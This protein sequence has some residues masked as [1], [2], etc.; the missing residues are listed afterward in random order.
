MLQ[1]QPWQ[2]CR[3]LAAQLLI[4]GITGNWVFVPE[5][6]S[7]LPPLTQSGLCNL[8]PALN[9]IILRLSEGAIDDACLRDVE[10]PAAFD[11]VL[12]TQTARNCAPDMTFQICWSSV[13]DSR[14][15]LPR[16]SISAILL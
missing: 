15:I 1:E 9:N 11:P 14:V 3:V 10:P 2:G 8:H 6:I 12:R 4:N 16:W 7:D 5:A 13:T